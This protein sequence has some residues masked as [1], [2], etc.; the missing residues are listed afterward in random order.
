MA[1]SAKLKTK[2]SKENKITGLI[3]DIAPKLEGIESERLRYLVDKNPAKR[4]GWREGILINFPVKMHKDFKK[5]EKLFRDEGYEV[6]IGE[7]EGGNPEMLSF[8]MGKEFVEGVMEYKPRPGFSAEGRELAKKAGERVAER[9][10]V[11][12]IKPTKKKTIELNPK[13]KA[14][15]GQLEKVTEQVRDIYKA[16]YKA[17]NDYLKAFISDYGKLQKMLEGKKISARVKEMAR[18][19][20]KGANAEFWKEYAENRLSPPKKE[21]GL[22][23]PERKEQ[24][25]SKTPQEV[26]E[27]AGGKPI[28]VESERELKKEKEL[29]VS[30]EAMK[31]LRS[32]YKKK[33]GEDY[34]KLIERYNLLKGAFD[35]SKGLA[36]KYRLAHQIAE[37]TQAG[38]DVLKSFEKRFKKKFPSEAT[39]FKVMLSKI[40]SAR[41]TAVAASK[42]TIRELYAWTGESK[43]AKKYLERNKDKIEKMLELVDGD[44]LADVLDYIDAAVKSQLEATANPRPTPRVVL[45]RGTDF[46]VIRRGL[47]VLYAAKGLQTPVFKKTKAKR[48]ALK[49]KYILVDTSFTPELF[50]KPKKQDI[51][52]PADKDGN[53]FVKYKG[54]KIY[55]HPEQ[56]N[57]IESCLRE[58][59][60]GYTEIHKPG[61]LSAQVDAAGADLLVQY[62]HEKGWTNVELR[63]WTLGPARAGIHISE[64][65]ED[66]WDRPIALKPKEEVVPKELREKIAEDRV[67]DEMPAGPIELEPRTKRFGRVLDQPARRSKF[68]MQMQKERLEYLANNP[69]TQGTVFFENVGIAR[70]AAKLLRKEFIGRNDLRAVSIHILQDFWGQTEGAYLRIGELPENAFSQRSETPL[71]V[72]V[73]YKGGTILSK[74]ADRALLQEFLNGKTRKK[75]IRFNTGKEG[76]EALEAYLS[77]IGYPEDNILSARLTQPEIDALEP[78]EQQLIKGKEIWE[79]TLTSVPIPPAP[80]EEGKSVA[81]RGIRG[82]D[83]L[84][85]RRARKYYSSDAYRMRLRNWYG[86]SE[87]WLKA[88]LDEQSR[89]AGEKK[90]YFVS[91]G[92]QDP[93]NVYGTHSQD[94]NRL[95]A[96]QRAYTVLAA[97][98]QGFA[99]TVLGNDKRRLFW[100]NGIAKSHLADINL[101][102]RP[103]GAR[104]S[105]DVQAEVVKHMLYMHTGSGKMRDKKKAYPEDSD[106]MLAVLSKYKSI[107]EFADA[108][109]N[110]YAAAA[111]Y[112]TAMQ[113]T[114]EALA[115]DLAYMTLSPKEQARKKEATFDM[116]WRAYVSLVGFE[117]GQTPSANPEPKQLDKC[118]DALVNYLAGRGQNNRF[119]A[120]GHEYTTLETIV[121]RYNGKNVLAVPYIDEAGNIDP[122]WTYIVGDRVQKTAP[123]GYSYWK[124][125]LRDKDKMLKVRTKRS[126]V[127]SIGPA[128]LTFKYIW[129]TNPPELNITEKPPEREKRT[130]RLM[131]YPEYHGGHGYVTVANDLYWNKLGV[132]FDSSKEDVMPELDNE[133]LHLSTISGEMMEGESKFY[134]HP[135]RTRFNADGTEAELVED[136]PT[137]RTYAYS[138]AYIDFDSGDAVYLFRKAGDKIGSEKFRPANARR[139]AEMSD[140]ELKKEGVFKIR[141]GTFDRFTHKVDYKEGMK[142]KFDKYVMGSWAANSDD[143]RKMTKKEK[144][145]MVPEVDKNRHY[146]V[147]ESSHTASPA[148]ESMEVGSAEDIGVTGRMKEEGGLY[149]GGNVPDVFIIWR[150]EGE[151]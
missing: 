2:K 59:T 64:V 79:I 65:P 83:K 32:Q 142:E 124:K 25:V 76:K 56:K 53:V 63:P 91:H 48:K 136:Y 41:N 95:D 45:E 146:Y 7:H 111:I 54:R 74:S 27:Y 103:E 115:L 62:L 131:V 31:W 125:T 42:P 98:G 14:L 58:G 43:V 117:T 10:T 23:V 69:E 44:Q 145:E 90:R 102:E 99:S 17:G 82:G 49:G 66:H 15:M 67:A 114:E 28:R 122:K 55:L 134:I 21:E 148:R 96:D 150:G 75:Q 33:T 149:V 108:L 133:V 19:A 127:D 147:V 6:K 1:G 116:M 141:I 84:Q 26:I 100:Q 16:Q 104:F 47:S 39:A 8:Y 132:S 61:K 57:V 140:R 128:G 112:D 29:A 86:T 11:P 80:K 93:S 109:G 139:Y 121:V 22:K 97:G 24:V 9:Y 71:S 118:A 38:Y 78:R 81:V 101:V 20:L 30:E 13:E 70:N 12:D 129:G 107:D 144:G 85:K 130:K 88:R 3:S 35:A 72:P 18:N 50:V 51:L 60:E 94:Y 89:E 106:Q 110:E 143:L 105:Q 151:E 37:N 119:K 92:L 113:L 36:S 120:G 77:R 126:W 87:A 5:L 138:S 73:V 123:E 68:E 52:P 40:E 34:R 46:P 137:F 4:K 135:P